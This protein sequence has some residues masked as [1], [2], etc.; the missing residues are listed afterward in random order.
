MEAGSGS[1]I[2]DGFVLKRMKDIED[3]GAGFKSLTESIDTTTP[4]GRLIMNVMGAIAEFER[5]LIRER[6]RAGMRAAIERG[7]QIGQPPKLSP[8]QVTD[9]QKMRDKGI[10]A[11]I[12]AKT[13]KVAPGT[14]Y[15]HTVGPTRSRTKIK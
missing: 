14:I 13:F 2:T 4:G 15:N 9:A 11:R 7:Q 10:S 1:A 5:D 3:A 6:T 12:I 8:K